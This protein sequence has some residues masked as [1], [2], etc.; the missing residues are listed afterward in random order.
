M[1]TLLPFIKITTILPKLVDVIFKT[2]SY[3]NNKIT[4][5]NQAITPVHVSVPSFCAFF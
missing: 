2:N 4:S 3:S 5:E 1:K